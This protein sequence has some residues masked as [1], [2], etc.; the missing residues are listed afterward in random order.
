G[1]VFP[2]LFDET[3]DVARAY[4][5]ACT[6]DFFLFDHDRRLAYR[7]QFDGSR[8]GNDVPVTGVDLRTAMEAVLSD[9]PV[10][11]DQTPSIGCS[12]KW[13]PGNQPVSIG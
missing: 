11:G 6:P 2:V 9:G 10:P 7:G 3:Q 4:R 8:P 13:R 12:I 1:Y 5:A